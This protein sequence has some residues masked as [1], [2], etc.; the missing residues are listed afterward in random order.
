MTKCESSGSL[1]SRNPTMKIYS[2]TNI[3]MSNVLFLSL[4]LIL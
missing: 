4:S 1:W 2:S 3:N